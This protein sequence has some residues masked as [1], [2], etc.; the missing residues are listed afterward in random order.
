MKHLLRLLPSLRSYWGQ[1]TL[2]LF[3]LLV[4][5]GLGLLVPAIIQRVIDVGIKNEDLAYLLK[6]ALLI[7]GIGA[8]HAVLIYFQRYLSEWIAQKIG[9]DMR[10][11]L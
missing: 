5:T 2:S 4:L 3:L 6:S 9:Y 8:A 10:N 1:I 7:L 11:R